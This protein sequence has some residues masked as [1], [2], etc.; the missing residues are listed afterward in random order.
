MP[1]NNNKNKNMNSK[2][3][4]NNRPPKNKR[5]PSS[6]V[7]QMV[8]PGP[9]LSHCAMKYALA[10]A[11]PW[12]PD[13]EGACVPR[14]PSRPS[15]KVRGFSRA[16]VTIGTAGAGFAMFS[17]TVANDATVLTY[18]TSSY[19]G[20]LFSD[21]VVGGTTTGASQASMSNLPFAKADLVP[22][23]SGSVAATPPINARMVSAALSW[24]YT[25]TVGNMGGLTYALVHPDHS[26]LCTISSTIASFAETDVSRVDNKR[27][28]C[29]L[30]GI[31]DEECNYSNHH[32]SG[33]ARTQVAICYP[34]SNNEAIDATNTTI[35]GAP[36]VVWF[37]GVA[38]NTFEVEL[39]THL[40]YTGSKAQAAVTPSHADSVGFEIVQS[41]SSKLPSLIQAHPTKSRSSLM[42]DALHSVGRELAPVVRLGAQQ[43]VSSG[44]RAIA[45]AAFGFLAGGPAGAVYGGALGVSTGQ[46]L[47]KN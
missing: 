12:H 19:T 42:S 4:R 47:L 39:V 6:R 18:S 20:A 23:S 35:G 15:Y 38:G 11:D 40:E 44:A 21:T 17:P 34:F 8:S 33:T 14:H 2:N 36:V 28:W 26:N 16:T 29:G 37:T 7:K 1:K 41:A 32:S 25:G 22:S 3:K 46:L 27:H 45:G 10:I 9:T 43:L 30:S 24:Q 31:D 13:A 5:N